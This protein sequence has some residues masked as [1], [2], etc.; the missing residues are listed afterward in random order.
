M[1]QQQPEPQAERGDPAAEQQEMEAL[2]RHW[3]AWNDPVL[4]DQRAA[5]AAAEAESERIWQENRIG[6]RGG[7]AQHREVQAETEPEL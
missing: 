4:M 3:A 6:L 7:P 2:E 1:S 5:D